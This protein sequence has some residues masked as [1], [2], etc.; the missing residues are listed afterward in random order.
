MMY[1]IKLASQ[2]ELEKNFPI[3]TIEKAEE[4]KGKRIT[5]KCF[6]LNCNGSDVNNFIVGDIISE[7]DFSKSIDKNS[8][9]WDKSSKFDNQQDY[10]KSYL[11]E[12]EIRM[13]KNIFKLLDH[14][15][16]DMFIFA[17]K[18]SGAFRTSAIDKY[19]HY[20]ID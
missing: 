17:F 18:S 7:W 1:D 8:D 2:S 3:L 14:N 5:T 13:R 16:K 15:D 20:Q 9:K 19:V 10:W 6:G 12:S 4:L 11:S